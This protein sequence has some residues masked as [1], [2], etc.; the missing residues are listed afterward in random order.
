MEIGDRK[1]VVLVEVQEE[2]LILRLGH[3][4][5]AARVGR[6]QDVVLSPIAL[7]V[8]FNTQ[9]AFRDFDASRTIAVDAHRAEM[10]NMNVLA[11]LNDGS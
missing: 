10:H 1:L 8:Q 9:I 6:M 7:D 4:V 3:M 2:Q 5:D 11:R